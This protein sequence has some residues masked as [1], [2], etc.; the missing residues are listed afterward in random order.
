MELE[1]M[2]EERS[3]KDAK[4]TTMATQIAHLNGEVHDKN[5]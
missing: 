2:K 5:A 4:I 1:K 3:N